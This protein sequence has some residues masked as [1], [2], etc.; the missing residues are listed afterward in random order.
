MKK[1]RRF[2]CAFLSLLLVFVMIPSGEVQA[3]TWTKAAV[4][5]ELNAT[6][7]MVKQYKALYEED[8]ARVNE[9]NKGV[10]YIYSD[11]YS[12]SYAV[13]IG[14]YLCVR[15]FSSGVLYA[16]ESGGSSLNITPMSDGSYL[17]SGYIKPTGKVE[18]AGTN[19]ITYVSGTNKA[20]NKYS[21]KLKRLE[22]K[23][24]NL[25]DALSWKYSF[26]K[27][28]K[29]AKFKVGQE[30]SIKKYVDYSGNKYNKPIFV[31]EDNDYLELEEDGTLTVKAAGSVKVSVKASV[32][33]KKTTV[34]I[35]C[36]DTSGSN[37]NN[38]NG[39]GESTQTNNNNNQTNTNSNNQTNSNTS[40][41]Y[42]LT[43]DYLPAGSTNDFTFEKQY[44]DTY[45]CKKVYSGDKIQLNPSPS[46]SS[47]YNYTYQCYNNDVSITQDGLVTMPTYDSYLGDAYS[48][49]DVLVS[50]GD[51]YIYKIQFWFF[52]KPKE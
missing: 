21:N 4:K 52:G 40:V 30:Y 13:Y 23:E 45:L 12:Y 50:C 25:R 27:K 48:K 22:K 7:K 1:K 47:E 18:Y 35:N 19:Q 26:D 29:S 42:S 39:M 5:K 38:T 31:E 6:K 51:K 44:S 34:E 37:A 33:G 28:I 14:N 8:K 3:K 10:F 49:Y 16:I 20:K 15:D 24:D 46:P 41:T 17:V 36:K 32:S 43:A 9:Y 2:L 11:G